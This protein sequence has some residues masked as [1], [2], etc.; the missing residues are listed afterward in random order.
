MT[1]DE[2]AVKAEAKVLTF[3]ETTA[4][5]A[6][7][8]A[9]EV[10][11]KWR[12]FLQIHAGI[13]QGRYKA[14]KILE[15][16]KQKLLED[17]TWVQFLKT[18]GFPRTTAKRYLEHVDMVEKTIP[19]AIVRRILLQYTDPAKPRVLTAAQAVLK[20]NPN[21]P[22][23]Q[24][25][26]KIIEISSRPPVKQPKKFKDV[27]RSAYKALMALNDLEEAPDLPKTFSVSRSLGMIMLA[28]AHALKVPKAELPMDEPAEGPKWLTSKTP[29]PDGDITPYDLGTGT[30]G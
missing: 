28:A 27:T 1:K 2:G 22:P 24:Q 4:K 18:V 15:S 21:D 13:E 30:E 3:L 19:S 7:G 5:L 29:L 17:R 20:Q 23:Q 14:G 8:E 6:R 25:V 11:G 10:E 12:G 16:I 9:A 26:A